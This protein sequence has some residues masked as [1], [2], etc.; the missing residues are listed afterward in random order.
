MG[1][2]PLEATWP[3]LEVQG[4]RQGVRETVDGSQARLQRERLPMAREGQGGMDRSSSLLPLL[5]DPLGSFA[6]APGPRWRL[7]FG[8]VLGK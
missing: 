5:Q 4:N 2:C 3:G 7:R 8:P 6:L 1:K